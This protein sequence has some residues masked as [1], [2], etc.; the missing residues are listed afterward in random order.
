MG[1]QRVGHDWATEL[2]WTECYL[3][4]QCSPWKGSSK[5]NHHLKQ[6][7]KK[8]IRVL[9]ARND[10]TLFSDSQASGDQNSSPISSYWKLSDLPNIELGQQ[11]FKTN[12]NNPLILC[13]LLLLSSSF[14]LLWR[15]LAQ[16]HKTWLTHILGY[17]KSKLFKKNLLCGKIFRRIK[18]TQ[19]KSFISFKL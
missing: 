4:S 7:C 13:F 17:Q 1:S 2:N 9:S 8:W 6:I 3:I 15:S 12:T 16:C 18:L 5:W 10:H 19:L 14:K 11:E